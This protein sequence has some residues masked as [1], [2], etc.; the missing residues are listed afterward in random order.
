MP[1][2]IVAPSVAAA[3]PEFREFVTANTRITAAPVQGGKQ[4]KGFDMSG[5]ALREFSGRFEFEVVPSPLI[6][7]STFRVRVFLRNE[8]KN[9]AKLDTLTAKILR[10][11][12]VSTASIRIMEDDIKIDQR[13]LVTEVVGPWV[14]GTT[15]WVMDVEAFSKKGERFR[16]SL[17]MKQP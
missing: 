3:A 15:Q 13:P 2:P 17:T 12:E 4:P 10:N 8:G 6:P 11:G 1:T 14:A 9:D 16:T 7:G 5:V